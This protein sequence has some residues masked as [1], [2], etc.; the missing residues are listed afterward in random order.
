[1]NEQIV[2][3]I[4]HEIE[5]LVYRISRINDCDDIE[6]LKYIAENITDYLNELEIE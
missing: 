3:L 1:M 5:D 4:K 6:Y 2:I